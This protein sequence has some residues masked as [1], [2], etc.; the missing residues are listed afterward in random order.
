MPG[1]RVLITGVSNFW[2]TELATRL[3]ADDGVARVVGIDSQRPAAP[4]DGVELIEADLRS[5][6]LRELLAGLDVDTIVHNEVNQ[7]P[8]P[9][10]RARQLH[11]INVIGTLNLLTAAERLPN[12]ETIVLRGSASI[13]GSEPGSP[14]F[15]PEELARQAPLRTRFQRD[16]GEL[17]KLVDAFARRRP[18]VTCTML[19]LQPVLGLRLAN[20]ITHLLRLPAVPTFLGFDPRVQFLHE[21]D[22]VDAL[23]A[24]VAR[25]L[26]GPV[27]VAGE[28]TV[29]LHWAL[30]RLGRTP[31]P[32]P[33]PLFGTVVGA[34]QRAGALEMTPD[35]ARYLRYGRGVDT[36]RMREELGLRPRL[37]TVDIV[38][39]LARGLKATPVAQAA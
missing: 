21:D 4:L 15:V 13:Y 5:D 1:R 7:F 23:A 6:G 25:P 16:L 39:T 29:S 35:M 10:R 17:E 12:L 14:D 27:N 32:I 37:R 19:R 36:T 34:M 22:S 33:H 20:P 18:Q 2:G 28:G 31:I 9:G 8:A 38:E 3:A 30:R 24:A 11:D 26:R